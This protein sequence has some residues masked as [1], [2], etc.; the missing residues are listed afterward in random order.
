[1][2][3]LHEEPQ[4]CFATGCSRPPLK[5]DSKCRTAQAESLQNLCNDRKCLRPRWMIV[6]QA[7][8]SFKGKPDR[9]GRCRPV[10]SHAVQNLPAFFL[11]GK[12][13]QSTAQSRIPGLQDK[14]LQHVPWSLGVG[15]PSVGAIWPQPRLHSGCRFA[16]SIRDEVV[17]VAARHSMVRF[18]V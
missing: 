17:G 10:Q 16:I 4:D 9:Q 1:M 2:S 6:L 3:A 5:P 11:E 18:E 12:Q 15:V 13:I 14:V 8:T 7:E